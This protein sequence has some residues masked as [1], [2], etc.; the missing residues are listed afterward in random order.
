MPSNHYTPEAPNIITPRAFALG[1]YLRGTTIGVWLAAAGIVATFAHDTSAAQALL[2]LV[3][4]VMLALFSGF[5]ARAL[6]NGLDGAS[7]ESVSSPR[8]QG[9]LAPRATAF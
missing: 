6:L 1:L 4:G 2:L 3:S 7:T 5:R 8:T 9:T